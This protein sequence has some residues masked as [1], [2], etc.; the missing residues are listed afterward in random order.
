[1]GVQGANG[2]GSPAHDDRVG[3]RAP[4]GA[5]Y[6]ACSHALTRRSTAR[7]TNNEPT[8]KEKAREQRHE[9]VRE[10]DKRRDA[11]PRGGERGA[12]AQSNQQRHTRPTANGPWLRTSSWPLRTTTHPRPLTATCNMQ[13]STIAE[14]P[15]FLADHHAAL[16]TPNLHPP[17]LSTATL[18]RR[19]PPLP[20][21][22]GFLSPSP[23]YLIVHDRVHRSCEIIINKRPMKV[24][25]HHVLLP[26]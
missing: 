15:T 17:R 23:P 8:Q 6:S 12:R 2:A 4:G 11:A 18:L 25:S 14:L 10:Y 7:T 9:Q 21:S 3:R 19:L 16:Q 13:P 22:R 26:L 24:P 5:K 20:C 1:V